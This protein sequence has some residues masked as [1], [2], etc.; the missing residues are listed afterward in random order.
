M[1][2]TTKPLYAQL[3]FWHLLVL[4]S[5]LTLALLGRPPE[6]QAG[7]LTGQPCLIEWISP[8]FA[9]RGQA[10]G[11]NHGQDHGWCYLADSW[12][13]PGLRCLLLMGLWP[14]TGRRWPAVLVFWPWLL[15]LWRGLVVVWPEWA[16][17]PGWQRGYW[18][19]WQGQQV[20]VCSAVSLGVSLWLRQ[21]LASPVGGEAWLTQANQ[22]L[23]LPTPGGWGLSLN[24]LVCSQTEPWVEV[25][26]E[27]DGSYTATLCGHFSFHIAGDDLFQQRLAILFLR[28]LEAPGP[29]R[30]GRRT[31]DGRTP[32][33]SQEKLSAW[34]DIPQPH[35]SRFEKYWRDKDWANLLSLKAAEVLSSDLIARIV[36]VFVT[37]PWWGVDKVRDHL[38]R[39]GV[40]VTERQVR[41]AAEQSGWSQLHQALLKRYELTVDSFWPRDNWLVADLLALLQTL[42][43]KLEAGQRLTPEEQLPVADLQALAAEVGAVAAPALKALPWLLC[44]E[45]VAFGH[46]QEVTDDSVRCLYCGSTH[47]VRKSRKPRLKK[48][49]DA[50]GKLQTVEVYRYYCRNPACD[51]GSFT[52]LP[53]GLVPYSPYRT[54][55]HLLA[56]QMYGWGRSTYRCTAQALAVANMTAYRWVSAWGY[57]LLPVAALFG[58]VKSSGVVGIDEKYVL[59]PKNDKPAG[60]MRRWMYVYLAVDVHTYDLLH[61]ALYPHNDQDSAQAFLLALRAKSYHPRVVVTDLRQDYGPVI[62]Q[63]FPTAQHHECIFHA[64]QTVQDHIKDVY[65]PGYADT[66]PEAEVLKQ[67][68]YRIFDTQSKR[69]AQERYKAV[70]ADRKRYVEDTPT[71]ATIFDFLERHW[72]TLVNGI[73]SPC[74]PTTNNTVELVILRFDQHYHNFR[75]FESIDSTRLFLAVFEKLYRFTPFSQDAQPAIRGKCPLQLA[76]YDLSQVPM[77]SLCAGLSVDW[78]VEVAHSHVPNR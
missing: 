41:L 16:R 4:I 56:M 77:A 44:V 75:G 38:Q 61:I 12:L 3:L 34:F 20:V 52:H 9:T 35:L 30:S 53:P 45:R 5:V 10:V 14:V 26:A 55:V 28:Q 15:W 62:A 47:V 78:P 48:Y 17:R 68:I 73:E 6:S 71:A 76:G 8:R 46:W 50:E 31:R 19:L 57:A 42:L 23:A 32:F 49:Y 74:I 2:H 70:M 27:A 18:L 13:Q 65:G 60:K 1:K 63:V 33:V 11:L 36:A 22:R 25:Y 66:H 64:L 21:I 67:A 72:P 58:V 39:Q 59:V 40:K 24:C 54:Q 51:K 29:Q 7:W 69:T 43:S 37:F